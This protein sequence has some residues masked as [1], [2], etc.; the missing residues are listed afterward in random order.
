[1]YRTNLPRTNDT[2]N[3]NQTKAEQNH[4]HAYL[5]IDQVVPIIFLFSYDFTLK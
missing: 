1:M 3:P 2:T 4:V 5:Y